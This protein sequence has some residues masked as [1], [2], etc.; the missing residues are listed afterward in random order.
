MKA[1][2]IDHEQCTL[3]GLCVTTCVRRILHEQDGK[4]IC[5][6]PNGCIVCGHC[7]AVCPVDAPQIPQNRAQEF[8]PVP[9][10]KDYPT[11]DD[12]LNFFRA[13]RSIRIYD[14]KAV[15]REQIENIIQAG[16]FAPTGGNRQHME[17]VVISTPERIAQIRV[18][19]M[20][21][22]KDKA[23]GT[24]QTKELASDRSI[25]T[26]QY[27][28]TW[29]DIYRLHREGVDKLFYDAPVVIV[30]HF[31]LLG[32]VSEFVDAGLANMQMILMAESLGLGTC[33][34]GF[35][36]IAAENSPVLKKAMGIPLDHFVPIAFTVGYPGIKY[37]RLV[38]RRLAKVTWI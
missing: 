16:R 10:K 34:N 20:E 15:T 32:E 36:A 30:S 28:Q 18:M 9:A 31:A 35:L 2:M 13:R 21:I 11:P 12:L 19:I 25:L 23:N 6:D 22:L 27:F 26:K 4:I 3:C 38:S 14:T 33:F 1:M 17:Y 37:Q 5:A 24:T 8:L 7:K 29:Q